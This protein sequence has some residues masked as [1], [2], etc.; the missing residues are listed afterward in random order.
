MFSSIPRANASILFLKANSGLVYTTREKASAIK[1]SDFNL[2]GASLVAP[3]K[4]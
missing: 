2:G 1:S 3:K 4:V